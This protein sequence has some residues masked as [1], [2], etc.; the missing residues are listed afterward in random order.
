M[1]D[2]DTSFE[3]HSFV[4]SFKHDSLTLYNTYGGV[5][6]LFITLFPRDEWIRDL[7]SFFE[8]RGQEQKGIYHTL[9][10][11]REGMIESLDMDNLESLVQNIERTGGIQLDAF[12]GTQLL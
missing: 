9:W 10:G 7:I 1:F 12:R 4:I 11:F 6:E 2:L 8:S 3:G 5:D